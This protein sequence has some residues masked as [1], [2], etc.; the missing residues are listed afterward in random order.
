M[1][2]IRIGA[3]APREI[4][5]AGVHVDKKLLGLAKGRRRAP[6]SLGSTQPRTGP[7]A[8]MAKQVHKQVRRRRR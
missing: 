8:E 2:E 1:T 6:E 4:K 5:G 3:R 7:F